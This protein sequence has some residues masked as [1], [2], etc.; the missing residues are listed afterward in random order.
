MISQTERDVFILL[1][2]E[3]SPESSLSSEEQL[4]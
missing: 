3:D 2:V 1:L 4:K